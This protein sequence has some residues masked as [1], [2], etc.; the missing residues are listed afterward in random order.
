[1]DALVV[2][3][4]IGSSPYNVGFRPTFRVAFHFRLL[5]FLMPVLGWYAGIKIAGYVQAFDHWI[6]FLLLTWIGGKMIW[7]SLNGDE[8]KEAFHPHHL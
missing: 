2:S 6:A 8:E 4:V 1:M 3:V 7:G 5:Q